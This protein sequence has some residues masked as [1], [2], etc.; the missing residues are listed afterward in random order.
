MDSQT[1]NDRNTH[2]ATVQGKRLLLEQTITLFPEGTKG[3]KT[4]RDLKQSASHVLPSNLDNSSVSE[5]KHPAHYAASDS[6]QQEYL[7]G[8]GGVH[9]RR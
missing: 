6:Y 5:H 4:P 8:S 1:W 3:R 7:W 2:I 9:T